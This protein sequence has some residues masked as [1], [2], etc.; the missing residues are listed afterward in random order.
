MLDSYV[1]KNSNS[2]ILEL[3]YASDEISMAFSDVLSSILI[4]KNAFDD[5]PSP[6]AE[7][8]DEYLNMPLEWL[9]FDSLS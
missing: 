8:N 9:L 3:W 4:S 5:G 1:E 7:T 2:L 6:V